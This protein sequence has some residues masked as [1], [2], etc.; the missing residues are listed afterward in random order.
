MGCTPHGSAPHTAFDS[1]ALSEL[2]NERMWNEKRASFQKT[3]K[4]KDPRKQTQTEEGSQRSET[5]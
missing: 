2:L 4:D 3:G 1:A 5:V